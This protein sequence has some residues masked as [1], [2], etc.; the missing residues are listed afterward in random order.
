MTIYSESELILHPDGSIFHLRLCPDQISDT[1]LLVGDPGRVEF[2]G[3]HLENLEKLAE[4]RE[5][6][7][8]SGYYHHDKI[9]VVSTGIGTDNI[10]IVVNELD[11]LANIDLDLRQDK[12]VKRKLNLIRIGTSGS[13]QPDLE[14][15]TAVSSVW[16]VGL[17][18]VMKY[19]QRTPDTLRARFERSFLESV[20]WPEQLPKPYVVQGSKR[21]LKLVEPF[22]T[23]GITVS[24]HGFYGPQGRRLRAPLA[25]PDLNE[26][27][28]AFRFGELRTSNFEM[29]S[30]ALYGLAEILGHDALTVCLIIANRMAGSFIGDYNPLLDKLIANMLDAV[31]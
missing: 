20:R 7:S 4:N 23:A 13:L 8:I 19:Y 16:S 9:M 12:P 14:A 11:A 27:L 28:Q 24:A 25:V 15:G 31:V 10:D 21:L 1:I 22:S 3:R 2:V 30:S 29:E 5:F 6:I 17:D 26:R 18:G